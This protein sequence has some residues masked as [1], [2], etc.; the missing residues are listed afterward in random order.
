[1]TT[2]PCDPQKEGWL[3]E[4]FSSIQG[5]GLFAGC[6]QLFV[7]MSG[8]NLQCSFCDVPISL[9]KADSFRIE[10]TPGSFD[11]IHIPNPV[12]EAD[13]IKI[14]HRFD[15]YPHHSISFTGGEPLLQAEFLSLVFKKLKQE[16]NIIYLETNGTLPDKLKIVL[17]YVDIIAMDIK[18][19]STANIEEHWMEHEDFL[20]LAKKHSLFVK[21]VLD[22]KED[23]QELEQACRL[24]SS[25]SKDIPLILQPLTKP[26]GKIDFNIP[27]F[28]KSIDKA[29]SYLSQVRL[30][31][32]THKQ[33]ENLL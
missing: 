10:E 19:P 29:L 20:R 8:C 17:P 30:I 2:S 23:S 22:K 12:S 1:M 13:L 32:Q 9:K 33:L 21:I 18:I 24:I 5:E 31:P 6:R 14:I 26:N 4:V 27:Y 16:G 28:I 3:S 7:R 15:S 25:V 11:F